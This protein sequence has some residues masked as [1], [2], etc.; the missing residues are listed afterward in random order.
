MTEPGPVRRIVPVHPASNDTRS[1][2]LIN[3][4]D[5]PDDD[6]LGLRRVLAQAG[7]DLYGTKDVQDAIT[8]SYVWLADQIGHLALGLIPTLLYCWAFA[9]AWTCLLAKGHALN[10]LWR[11]T[12]LIVG[13]ALLFLYWVKKERTDYNDCWNRRG[14]QFPFDS[15]DIW[16]NV[17]TALF[18]IGCG[19]VFAVCAFFGVWWLLAGF[20]VLI[21][22]AL[23]IAFWWLKRKLAFQQAGL[24]FLFR[25]ANF[26]F[27][28][29]PQNL[30]TVGAIAN[31]KE[32]EVSFYQVCFGADE[33]APNAPSI[34]HVLLTG[35]LGSG[36]TTLA[37]GTGTEFAFALGIGRYLTAAK[38]IQSIADTK[39]AP[40]DQME[41]DDG[42]TLWPLRQSDLLIV[43]DLDAGVS[44]EGGAALHL[45]RP[46]D[47]CN[48]LGGG[49]ASTL[50]WLGAR[51]SIWVIG[52]KTLAPAWLT[53]IA[54]LIGVPSEEI[55]QIDLSSAGIALP[56]PSTSSG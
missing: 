8:A 1:N 35:P 48:A 31:L 19:S 39:D 41:L 43:D 11:V 20:A 4:L 36:K 13:S 56:H 42:R 30:G 6:P 15:S 38:L 3:K 18:Y 5:R 49:G 21:W 27:A 32:R 37:V 54:Q 55:L 23:R 9:G 24:P 22:P 46:G 26:R 17:K 25:L 47:F 44:V 51:R 50:K 45:V 40:D 34:R 10:D 14:K 29:S 7:R 12:G 52:D 2:R 28:L 16:W 53:A 33:I